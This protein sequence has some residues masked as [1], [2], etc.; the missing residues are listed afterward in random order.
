MRLTDK[1]GSTAIEASTS[2]PDRAVGAFSDREKF[3]LPVLSL[4]FGIHIGGGGLRRSDVS[5][6]SDR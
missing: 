6:A 2:G 3:F 1:T 5:L 4:P